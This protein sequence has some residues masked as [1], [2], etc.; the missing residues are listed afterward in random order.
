MTEWS[1][2]LR[3]GRSVF[4]R[5][6]SSPTACIFPFSF[7]IHSSVAFLF[8]LI[9]FYSYSPT[10]IANTNGIDQKVFGTRKDAH[11]IGGPHALRVP[12]Y[13]R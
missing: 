9:Y 6:G 2:V 5:V 8:Y 7:L 10:V 1:K 13:G 12:C 11:A 3:S 4:A